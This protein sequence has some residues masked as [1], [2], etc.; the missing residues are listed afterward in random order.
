MSPSSPFNSSPSVWKRQINLDF[1]IFSM[2]PLPDYPITSLCCHHSLMS[3]AVPSKTIR[4]L[5]YRYH[6]CR[7]ID[8]VWQFLNRCVERNGLYQ[9]VKRGIPRGSS[10]SPLL[11]AF[12]LMELDRNITSLVCFPLKWRATNVQ[13]VAVFLVPRIGP[14]LEWLLLFPCFSRR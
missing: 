10:L 12:Y 11:G 8:Y 13:V 6:D 1:L 2:Q 5:H 14:V 9:E 7:I 3:S 4:C